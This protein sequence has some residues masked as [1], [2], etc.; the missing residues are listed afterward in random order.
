[1]GPK[2]RIRFN[3]KEYS[4]PDEL[5]PEV[6]AALEKAVADG[7]VRKKVIVNGLEFIDADQMPDS[8][9][10]LYDD[11]MRVIENNGEVTLPKSR[12]F[13]PLLTKRQV[14]AVILVVGM[15]FGLTV[16]ALFKR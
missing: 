16:L 2:T 13:E 9:R 11:I 1:M 14:Q 10:R 15:L 8:A 6:R 5:P 4:G 7:T 12:R 3:G